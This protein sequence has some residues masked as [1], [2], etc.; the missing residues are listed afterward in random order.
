MIHEYLSLPLRG[1][2]SLSRLSSPTMC[3]GLI[4]SVKHNTGSVIRLQLT[5]KHV[6]HIYSTYQHQ[7]SHNVLFSNVTLSNVMVY[8]LFFP[9]A[10][11][12]RNAI[13]WKTN[14]FLNWAEMLRAHLSLVCMCPKGHPQTLI[15]PKQT[16]MSCWSFDRKF[17]PSFCCGN[18]AHSHKTYTGIEDI[19][20]HIQYAHTLTHSFWCQ[21]I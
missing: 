1:S 21:S 11:P 5:N 8:C 15:Q 20:R 6:H 7:T 14:A 13:T 18:T 3:C 2:S 16:L 9:Q 12:R 10:S 4:C 17:T 19:C